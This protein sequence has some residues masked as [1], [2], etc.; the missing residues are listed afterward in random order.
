MYRNEH[1][2]LNHMKKDKVPIIKCFPRPDNLV[3]MFWCHECEKFH[4]HGLGA[5]HR[6]S[7]GRGNPK[8]K[9]G[10]ILKLHSKKTLK[11]IHKT[12]CETR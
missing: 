10:Y 12:I 8:L 9:N 3:L 11:R 2:G 6:A 7:H 1:I 5:G 4:I